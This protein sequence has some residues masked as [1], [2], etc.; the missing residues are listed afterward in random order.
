MIV[1]SSLCGPVMD[2]WLDP[3][4]H[5]VAAGHVHQ[6]PPRPEEEKIMDGWIV[7]LIFFIVLGGT[8]K[9]TV[10]CITADLCHRNCSFS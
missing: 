3:A 6:R 10:I 4:S 8:F 1:G 9:V 7:I 5:I 2:F